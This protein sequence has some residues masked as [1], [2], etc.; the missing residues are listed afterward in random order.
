ML[1]AQPLLRSATACRRPAPRSAAPTSEAPVKLPRCDA[2]EWLIAGLPLW[3][4]SRGSTFKSDFIQLN[5][6]EFLLASTPLAAARLIALLAPRSLDLCPKRSVTTKF[7]P[8]S[9]MSAFFPGGLG[10]TPLCGATSGSSSLP[11]TED[12]NDGARVHHGRGGCSIWAASW[13]G[14]AAVAAAVAVAAPP[15]TF[16]ASR[17]H[18]WDRTQNG[19][20][21]V[22]DM[23][24]RL[25]L[26]WN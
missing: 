17:A 23:K 21:T 5:C 9:W 26:V 19:P 18:L 4:C 11:A 7:A 24:V 16:P 14:S 12:G 6:C 2:P 20:V 13:G 25:V 1:P 15:R 3:L 8:Q 22:V 10:R